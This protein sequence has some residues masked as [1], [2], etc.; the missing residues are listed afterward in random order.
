MADALTTAE[1]QL[2]RAAMA[3]AESE[4]SRAERRAV[5]KA[6]RVAEDRERDKLLRELPKG[7]YCSLAGK[8]QRT[9]DDQARRYK[10]GSLLGRTVNLYEVI[11]E[12]HQL[13]AH[14]KGHLAALG[15]TMDADLATEE[16]R[17]KLTELQTRNAKN[18]LEY[19]QLSGRLLDRKEL[20]HL[21]GWLANELRGLG[22][23]L[24]AK[25]GPPAAELLGRRLDA[26]EREV[27]RGLNDSASK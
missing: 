12:L 26:I 15:E 19:D 8:Q 11:A 9:I 3:K 18:K 4:W 5:E 24:E 17:A 27:M 7:L 14:N 22:S 6:H 20:E 1:Q 16:R 21:F 10:L 2:A 13:V 23:Q 25:Y